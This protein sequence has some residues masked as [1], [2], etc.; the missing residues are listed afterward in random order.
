M[1]Q[2]TWW[3][4]STKKMWTPASQ[5]QKLVSFTR[6]FPQ[7]PEL[8][9][10]TRF[11]LF[12]IPKITMESFTSFVLRC[13]AL[14][15]DED[16]K[17]QLQ[18]LDDRV[19]DSENHCNE[20][21]ISPSQT[22]QFWHC[23][24]YSF[25]EKPVQLPLR[26]RAYTIRFVASLFDI[27][28]LSSIRLLLLCFV[29]SHNFFFFASSFCVLALLPIHFVWFSHWIFNCFVCILLTQRML[30]SKLN[31]PSPLSTFMAQR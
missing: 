22:W 16:P 17:T 11:F 8:V 5:I 9:S 26:I 27:F 6:F 15:E 1:V 24:D 29:F 25:P 13:D 12:T 4:I 19:F 30:E 3:A 10:F 31:Y 2:K 28:V 18:S 20:V 14:T 23:C 7:L 21:S